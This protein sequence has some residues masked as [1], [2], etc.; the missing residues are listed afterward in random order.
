M[1]NAMDDPSDESVVVEAAV[2]I[3]RSGSVTGRAMLEAIIDPVVEKLPTAAL[4][5]GFLL[6]LASAL[7]C[8]SLDHLGLDETRA[9]FGSICDALAV[10]AAQSRICG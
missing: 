1:M 2:Q 10:G 3:P 7:A 8:K 6:E 4:T 5:R 9:L